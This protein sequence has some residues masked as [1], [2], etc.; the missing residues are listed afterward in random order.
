MRSLESNG[1]SLGIDI[2]GTKLLATVLEA[3]GTTSFSRKYPTGRVFSPTDCVRT[4]RQAV[5]DSVAETGDLVGIGIGFPGLV[6]PR[7]GSVRS[8]VILNGWDNVALTSLVTAATGLPCGI[9]NDVNQAARAELPVRDADSFFFVAAGTG[10]GGAVVLDGKVWPGVSGLAGEF[11]HICIDREGADCICGRRGCVGPYA[12]GE[13]IEQRLGIEP[14][15]LAD[16]MQSNPDVANEALTEA[17]TALGSAIAS[18]MN[19]MNVGLVVLG[20]GLA[21][22][23]PYRSAVETAARNE[24]FDEIQADCSF[25]VSTAGYEAGATGAALQGREVA[26]AQTIK[27]KIA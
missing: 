5:N 3:D 12:G 24:A 27:L 16:F 13:G 26:S 11:G 15:T 4:I 14:G 19:V 17:G 2:G 18:I 1:R 25:E 20:G 9:D 8:S 23:E 7:A 22:L 10:I 21:M 6:D